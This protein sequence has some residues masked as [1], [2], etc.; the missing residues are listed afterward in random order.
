[1]I[2]YMVACRIIS[3]VAGGIVHLVL[4]GCPRESKYVSDSNQMQHHL[5]KT[6]FSNQSGR[7]GA[8]SAASTDLG[9]RKD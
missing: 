3:L 5:L 8:Y 1:M 4:P 6:H 9:G 2:V 7:D